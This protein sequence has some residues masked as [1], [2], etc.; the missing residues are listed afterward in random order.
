MWVWQYA[1]EVLRGAVNVRYLYMYVHGQPSVGVA[2][3]VHVAVLEHS[4]LPPLGT[5]GHSTLPPL[6]TLGHSTLPPLGTLGHSTLPPQE[7]VEGR[8]NAYLASW[9]IGSSG[10]WP[11]QLVAMNIITIALGVR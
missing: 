8:N 6:G 3:C 1:K 2:T 9:G 5:L 7:G 4:T 10:G 11:G